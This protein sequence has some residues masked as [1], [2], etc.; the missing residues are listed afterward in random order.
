MMIEGAECS[1]FFFGRLAE[2]LLQEFAK[3]SSRNGRAGSNP[4]PSAKYI[5]YMK[6]K[7]AIFLNEPAASESCVNGIMQALK[8][9]RF[10]LFSK[11]TFQ[12]VDFSTIDLVAFPG[13]YGEADLFNRLVRPNAQIITNYM[14][15]G[16][17]FLGICMGAY[18]ADKKYFNFLKDVRAVQY[19]TR[20][21]SEIRRSYSTIANV[22]WSREYHSMY[23]YDG[24]AFIG[25][26]KYKRVATYANGDAM[27]LIQGRVGVIGCHPESMKHWYKKPYMREY[28]HDG[29]HHA[30]LHGFVERLMRT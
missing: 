12:N 9:Y 28:W 8:G 13:G 6:P 14:N 7:V 10:Q 22:K 18:W 3:F 4:A 5:L 15:N 21:R 11:K 16:G 25:E 26:G 27:A 23:F 2:R 30:L 1:L 20:P 19:I 17:R 24:T 29:E